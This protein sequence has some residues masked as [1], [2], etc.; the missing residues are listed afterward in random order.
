MSRV[1]T[2]IKNDGCHQSMALDLILRTFI[3]SKEFNEMPQKN[4]EAVSRLI[5][6]T[7]PRQI[8]R[9]YEELQQQQPLAPL[10]ND[11]NSLFGKNISYGGGNVSFMASKLSR[12]DSETSSQEKTEQKSHSRPTSAKVKTSSSGSVSRSDKESSSKS[13]NSGSSLSDAGPMMVIH[14]CDEAKNVKQDFQCPRDLLITEMKY[15]ADY[16]STD[17][18]R[19]EEVDISVHCDVQI[20]DWLM[21]YVKR[22]IKDMPEPTKLEPNN[23]ISILI[24]SDF[25]KMDSLVQKCI[26]Y[27]HGHMNAILAT[28]C[29]MNCIN[30][31]LVTRIADLFNHNELDDIKDRKDKFKSKLFCKKVEKL[32]ESENSTLCSPENASTLFRCGVCKK[33]LTK[34]LQS[35]VKCA[36]S[37]MTI[38]QKGQLQ[39]SHQRDQN[40]DVNEFILDLKNELKTWREV[41]WRI[42]GAVNYLQCSRCKETFPCSYLGGCKMHLEQ[43]VFVDTD[44]CGGLIGTFPC[45]KQKSLRFDPKQPNTGCR[46]RDHVVSIPSHAGVDGATQAKSRVYDDLLAHKDAICMPPVETEEPDDNEV[47]VFIYEEHACGLKN[48][49][50]SSSKSKIDQKVPQPDEEKKE[51]PQ[52]RLE[53]LMYER[54]IAFDDDIGFG[55]S[56]DEL[57]DDEI[58]KGKRPKLTRKSKFT[59]DPQAILMDAPDF[60]IEKNRKWASD[61]SMR[62]NQDAQREDDRRRMNEI[63]SY[64]TKLR[65]NAEK[66]EKIKHKEYAGGI[67]SKLD[68]QW[69]MS[70]LVPASKGSSMAQLRAKPRPGQ[71]RASIT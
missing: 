1:N 29:N 55:E 66:R 50:S 57:G 13:R 47:N 17:A 26:E 60:S 12:P 27:C 69:K 35:K 11:I 62:W 54:Q 3:N 51:T 5:P 52:P 40:W 30:D 32:F 25:L 14:V 18:H 22:K 58:G 39:Y 70:N 8:A 67:F 21:K 37:R 15:F 36:Q 59:V 61:K 31:K 19:W 4:W 6:G 64:L 33:L 34:N 20:F 28:P 23:V 63:V 49:S 65:L 24:S 42:W 2:K 41:Y 7:T 44:S 71:I 68:A 16:L 45:C 46:S 48:D 9:R 53:P 10:A 43:P 38:D 56:E